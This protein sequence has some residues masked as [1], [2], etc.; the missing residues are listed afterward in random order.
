MA[1]ARQ[2]FYLRMVLPALILIFGLFGYLVGRAFYISFRAYNPLLMIDKFVGLDNYFKVLADPVFL[3][4][5]FRTLI[6]VG[7]C[8]GVGFIIGML[9]A[10][11]INRQFPGA[12]VLKVISI[13][14]MLLM[15]AAAST[16]WIMIYNYDFGIL[17][18]ALEAVGLQRQLI[19]SQQ[20]RAF[21]AVVFVDVWAWTP[22]LFL[23]FL[24]GLQSLPEEPFEAAKIDGASGWQRFWR[25]TL[26]LLKP[27]IMVGLLI[28]VL[29][30]LR[31]FDYIWVMTKGG[32]GNSSQ[33]LSTITYRY[34]FKQFNFGLGASM[35]ILILLISLVLAIILAKMLSQSERG[36]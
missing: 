30:T 32:P 6:Y 29:D 10:L 19:L 33:I 15:P 4:A 16:V 34:A 21:Y 7:I 17:N 27:V 36:V 1:H 11:F 14:P 9:M 22:F 12:N 24:A 18:H 23:I 2:K 8:I 3:M 25:I 5:A 28:K 20:Q 31:A 35:C 26:P 13:L